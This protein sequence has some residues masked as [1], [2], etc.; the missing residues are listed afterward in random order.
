MTKLKFLV[1]ALVLFIS[2]SSMFAASDPDLKSALRSEITK[3][4]KS[5][6]FEKINAESDVIHINFM[7]T[8]KNEI[9]VL[10]TDNKELDKAIKGSLNYK[11]VDAT[12]IDKNKLYTLPIR[13]ELSE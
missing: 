8:G 10:T 9:V 2:S 3:L 11:Q 13:L 5:I 7:V 6:D 1:T 12:D 4:F